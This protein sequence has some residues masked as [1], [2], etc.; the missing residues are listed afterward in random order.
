MKDLL[1]YLVE[2]IVENKEAIEIREAEENGMKILHLKVAAEDMGKVIGKGGKVI[3]SIRAAL[4]V[5]A[6][7]TKTRFQLVLDEVAQNEN[8]ENQI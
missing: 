5:K 4:R 8:A 1:S 3:K 6:L 7:Q 2:N